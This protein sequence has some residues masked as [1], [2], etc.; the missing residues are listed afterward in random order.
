MILWLVGMMGAGKTS[1]GRNAAKRLGIGF[2][3]TDD[4]VARDAG[5]SIVAIWN[6]GGEELFR[7]LEIDAVS[8]LA[9]AADNLV[10]AAGGGAVLSEE[11]RT[12]MKSSGKVVWLSAKESILVER[13]GASDGR[14]LLQPP[15]SV[16]ARITELMA[17]RESIYSEL[18]DAA[19]DVTEMDE[20]E[21]AM[22]VEA[23]WTHFQSV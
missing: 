18:A 13:I 6:R 23:L 5:L 1:T 17:E 3:D 11:N 12:A 9:A 19:V 14:P 22:E 20:N 15:N 8:R 21:A 4:E 7:E 10:I 16:A 2:S